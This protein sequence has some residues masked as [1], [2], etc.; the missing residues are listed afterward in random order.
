[1]NPRDGC[2]VYVRRDGQAAIVQWSGGRP[3]EIMATTTAQRPKRLTRR[4]LG[5]SITDVVLEVRRRRELR[6]IQLLRG[7]LDA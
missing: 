6:T 2:Y 5:N 3:V 7:E 1:M 4:R